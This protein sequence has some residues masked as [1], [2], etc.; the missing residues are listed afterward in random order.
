MSDVAW[1]FVAFLAVW[2]GLGAYLASLAARQRRLERRL[3]EV[4]RD[5]RGPDRGPYGH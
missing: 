5:A 2:A 4:A 3:D 1:L